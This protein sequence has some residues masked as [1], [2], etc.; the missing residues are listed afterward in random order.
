MPVNIGLVVEGSSPETTDAIV[1][2]SVGCAEMTNDGSWVEA[3]SPAI[4]LRKSR[5]E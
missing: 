5:L 2:K 3:E 4:S 1:P